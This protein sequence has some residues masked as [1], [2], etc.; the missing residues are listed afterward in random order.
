MMTRFASSGA[1]SGWMGFSVATVVVAV[2]ALSV[3]LAVIVNWQHLG[4]L[5]NE[6]CIVLAPESDAP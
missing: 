4:A 3:A 6:D 2:A 5:A 1:I